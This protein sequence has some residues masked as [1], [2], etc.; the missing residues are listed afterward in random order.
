MSLVS[1]YKVGDCYFY[2]Y[3]EDKKDIVFEYDDHLI[4]GNNSE[5]IPSDVPYDSLWVHIKPHLYII[6][7]R[8][9]GSR[10]INYLS[11]DCHVCLDISCLGDGISYKVYPRWRWKGC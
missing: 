7:C 1:L 3:H 9:C 6:K 5:I 10:D 11:S 8:R 4:S 2:A